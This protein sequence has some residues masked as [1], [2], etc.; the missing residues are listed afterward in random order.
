MNLLTILI[1]GLIFICLCANAKAQLGINTDGS[2]PDNSAM[3]DVKSTTKGFLAPRMTIAQRNAIVSPATGLLVFCTDNNQYYSNQGSPTSPSWVTLMSE[4]LTI[5]SNIYYGAGNVGIGCAQPHGPLQLSNLLGNRKIILYELANDDHQY[6]GFGINDHTLRYQ[7]N[8]TADRHAFFAGNGSSSSVEL[9][10]IQGNGTVAIGT[11][12]PSPSAALDV[13]SNNKGFLPPRMT[14]VQRD[15]VTSPATGLVIYQ[16]DNTSGY[17]YYSGANWVGLT[18]AG[19]GGNS[20]SMCIDYDGNA[21]PTFSIGTQTWMAESLRV[22]HYRN[23]EAIPNVTD[24]MAWNA[25]STGAYCWYNNEHSANSKYGALYN[26]YTVND[27]RGICPQGWH[28]PSYGEW[29][30]LTTY[31]GDIWVAGGRM[32]SISALW[33][34]PNADATNNSGFSGLPGGSRNLDGF[35]YLGVRGCFWSSSEYDPGIAWNIIL[36]FDDSIIYRYFYNEQ[37]G[38]SI[39][40]LRD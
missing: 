24:N 29:T 6:Y 35:N 16:T 39:R 27:S 7:V 32:K 21:Y 12:S 22:T 30:T 8:T 34:S 38:Y 2:A 15:A 18:G 11:T 25:L 13:N 17:Y 19:P 26:W 40:C 23:G 1:T 28:V 31:L 36:I 4:W 9:M 20:P 3:L 10:R 37:Y 14:K 33:A 5:G